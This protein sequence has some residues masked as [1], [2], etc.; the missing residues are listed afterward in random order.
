MSDKKLTDQHKDA[1]KPAAKSAEDFGPYIETDP[2]A[3][4]AANQAI[5]IIMG[6]LPYSED[7]DA[8]WGVPKAVLE[9]AG[10]ALA[11]R[12][13]F[14][15]ED[16]DGEIAVMTSPLRY[17]VENGCCSDQTG[18]ISD[19]IPK[20]GELMESS[21]EIYEK[22][23]DTAVDAAK[24]MQKQGFFWN[25]DF[26]NFIDASQTA[27]IAKAL[28]PAEKPANKSGAKPKF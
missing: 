22:G 26:Q 23:V 12:Y 16:M 11:N 2:A 10:K 7:D 13:I 24:Y 6:D 3:N 17:F 4:D 15:V 14:A 27:D 28:A 21:W 1:L 19:L 25:K 9:K 8:E 5:S 18:P 20:G